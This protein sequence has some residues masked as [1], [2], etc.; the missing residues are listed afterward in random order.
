M[1]ASQRAARQFII[2]MYRD[3]TITP[4]LR[5]VRVLILLTVVMVMAAPAGAGD[6]EVIF[7]AAVSEH[8]FNG[9]WDQ[10][11]TCMPDYR[12]E[13]KKLFSWG[14]TMNTGKMYRIHPDSRYEYYWDDLDRMVDWF[15]RSDMNLKYHTIVWDVNLPDWYSALSQEESRAALEEHVRTILSRY[16]GRI[17]MYDVVNEPMHKGDPDDYMGTGW[18]REE[19][20]TNIFIWANEED[21]DAILMVN[22]FY[23]LTNN[24]YYSVLDEYIDLINSVRTAGGPINAIG[25]QAHMGLITDSIALTDQTINTALDKLAEE[26]GLPIYI[27][28][29]DIC[30]PGCMECY[31]DQDGDPGDPIEGFDSWWQYQAATERRIYQ[32]FIDHPGVYGV[33]R[34]AYFDM[35][36]QT[37]SALFDS[38]FN[39]RPVYE[40]LQDILVPAPPSS[41]GPVI[42]APGQ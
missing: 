37:L 8:A 28:E 13:L 33:F 15:E 7:G 29:F 38:D 14:V 1:D 6:H 10:K 27:T 3:T 39:P 9:L 21:P 42:I 18:T 36:N 2:I 41:T 17:T 12:S 40:S 16:K 4:P 25:V 32:T 31:G 19:A 24:D 35:Y 34:W 23:V 20:I 11:Y 26:T 22:E 30:A 5:R